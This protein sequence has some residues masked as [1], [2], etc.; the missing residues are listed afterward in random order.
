[1]C[2]QYLLR[3][4]LDNNNIED[5]GIQILADS[6]TKDGFA[7]CLKILWLSENCITDK[8]AE[9]FGDALKTSLECLTEISLYR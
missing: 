3:L 1:M 6:F 4:H 5:E 7:P 2:R 9:V 8:G